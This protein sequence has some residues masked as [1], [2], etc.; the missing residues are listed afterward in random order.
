VL[1]LCALAAV[2]G[3]LVWQS[4]TPAAYPGG[5][6][7]AD[8]QRLP[9]QVGRLMPAGL[10]GAALLTVMTAS[11]PALYFGPA[12]MNLLFSAPFTRR[13][14]LLYKVCYYAAGASLS[15]LIIVL[16]LPPFANNALAAFVGSFLTL[17]FIQLF[18]AAF[19]S[20]SRLLNARRLVRLR[21]G[22]ALVLLAGLVFTALRLIVDAGGGLAGELGD[23]RDSW[24]GRL[25]LAPFEVFVNTLLA[26]AVYP[27]LIGWAALAVLINAA[28]L[29]II[30]RLDGRTYEASIAAS[31]A[32]HARWERLL[33]GGL[34]RTARPVAFRSPGR[35]P[36]LAGV[37]PV[38]WRQLLG[39]AR[40]SARPVAVFLVLALIAGPLLIHAAADVSP[41]SRAG[42]VFF[43]AVFVLPRTLVFDFRGDLEHM[44][45]LKALPLRAWAIC[46]GQLVAP[47][48]LSSMVGLV[49]IAATVPLLEGRP[50]MI[51]A[52]L[53]LFIVPFNLLLYALENLFFLLFPRPLVPV[54]RV[55][56]DFMGRTM[57]EF[58]VKAS[59]L[60][61]A[62]GLAA[63]LGL[64]ASR[65]TDGSR[66]ALAAAAWTTLT[67]TSLLMLPL[68]A[69]AFR[70]FDVS[71]G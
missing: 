40:V 63:G 1:F 35:A 12:E 30:F 46:A 4:S 67:L 61:G 39:V 68:L 60:I 27:D 32:V 20:V 3:L 70:R 47:V 54:G 34:F 2:V 71:R 41:W 5:T 52:A 25:L 69:R 43:V 50:R 58:A 51:V 15:S 19:G 66:L 14:L 9:E 62:C 6:P 7:L 11:G 38:A 64:V 31:E 26:P 13:A 18:S 29:A 57:V 33:K 44:E 56:F 36:L 8:P 28:L 16:V 17:M 45:N 53:A 21:R 37:G 22:V 23:L 55:D 10:L 42:M 65:A 49:L 59:L 48:L 24:F